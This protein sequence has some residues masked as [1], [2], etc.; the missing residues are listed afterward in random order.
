MCLL[1]AFFVANICDGCSVYRYGA[2]NTK[3]TKLQKVFLK[4]ICNCFVY[5]RSNF[6]ASIIMRLGHPVTLS[7]IVSLDK[8]C[9]ISA[10]IVHT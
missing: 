8:S 9:V 3:E 4:R 5:L 6:K 10:K 2:A 1:N 7:N